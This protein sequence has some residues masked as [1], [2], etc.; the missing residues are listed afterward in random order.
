[1]KN[2]F[3]YDSKLV[4][5]LSF[6]GDV[7][8]INL[9]YLIFCTPIV[10]IGAAQAGLHNATRILTDPMDDSS[11]AKAFLRGFKEGFFKITLATVLFFLV[12]A[13]LYYTLYISFTNA[14]TGVFVHWGIPLAGLCFS[15]VFQCTA[16]LFHSQFN[17]TFG[18]LLRNSA[19]MMIWHP[20]VS[21]VTTAL[22]C[23]PMVIFLGWT[24]LFLDITPFFLTVYFGLVSIVINR[25]S[26]KSFKMLIDHYNDPEAIDR[27]P[28]DEAEEKESPEAE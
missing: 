17:C 22:I 10:T 1:M 3:S 15:L 7:L 6:M 21:I 18:Q 16:N 12:D 23:I 4:S 20:L 24:Q 5:V 25:L 2:M 19:M 27:D 8:I 26:R 9:L 28:D 14:D 11:P 13:V